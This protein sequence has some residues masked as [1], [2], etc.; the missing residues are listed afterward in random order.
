MKKWA[1]IFV[2]T[3]GC[4][5]LK[6]FEFFFFLIFFSKYLFQFFLRV[7]PGPLANL[8]Y[9]KTRHSYL[10]MLRIVG[11]TAEPIGLKFLFSTG[12]AGPF[13]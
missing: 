3:Q 1:E 8:L 9:N 5:R 4:Y 11:Q 13:S 12:N 6:K 2:D 10:Y 7:M